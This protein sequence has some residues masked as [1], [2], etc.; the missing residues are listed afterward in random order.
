M[1]RPHVEVSRAPV[2][3]NYCNGCKGHPN[4][5]FPSFAD[6]KIGHVIITICDIC[7][8]QVVEELLR[9]YRPIWGLTCQQD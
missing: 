4:D 6:M 8:R 3:W 1:A 5:D 9:H 2:T 7:A